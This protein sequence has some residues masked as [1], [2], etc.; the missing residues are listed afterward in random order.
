MSYAKKRFIFSWIL[1]KVVSIGSAP[2]YENDVNFL[3]S[4]KIK[5]ILCLCSQEE[6][7]DVKK[8]KENFKFR[9]IILPD[10]KSNSIMSKSQIHNALNELNILKKEGKSIF[11][12]CNAGVERSPTIILAYLIYSEGYD[13]YVA[14]KYLMDVHPSSNPLTYQIDLVR[15]LYS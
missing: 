9:R 10:H 3:K 2:R 4:K 7:E 15:N 11:V 5:S 12:H 13:F 1:P 6:F 14:L 8:I